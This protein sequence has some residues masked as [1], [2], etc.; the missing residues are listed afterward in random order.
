[1]ERTFFLLG[2][3][4]GFVAVAAG[5]FG[6]HGLKDRLTPEMLN[7]FEVGARYQMYHAL[8]LLAAGWAQTRWPGGA[9]SA[10]G[11]LFV[12]GT[13]VFSGSLYLLSL[14]GARWLG[15]ITPLG[16]LAFLAGWLCLAWAALRS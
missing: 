14:T 12:A 5:A 3:A 2:A 10:A 6:A 9:A 8:A 15:A 16:G 11:W 13:L 7:T 1:M 4:S